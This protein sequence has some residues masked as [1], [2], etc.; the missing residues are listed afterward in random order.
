MLCNRQL[1]SRMARCRHCS[2]LAQMI[3]QNLLVFRDLASK[4]RP[5]HLSYGPLFSCFGVSFSGMWFAPSRLQWQLKLQR[6]RF[7]G[8]LKSL[9]RCSVSQFNSCFALASQHDTVGSRVKQVGQQGMAGSRVEC[10]NDGPGPPQVVGPVCPS[11]EIELQRTLPTK[12]NLRISRYS[13]VK[14]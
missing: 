11:N 5:R 6:V 3:W 12:W 14:T 2:I 10:T 7:S 8:P 4:S 13:R 9:Y 1:P